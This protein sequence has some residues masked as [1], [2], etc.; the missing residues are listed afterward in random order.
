M[1]ALELAIMEIEEITRDGQVSADD[2]IGMMENRYNLDNYEVMQ[3]VNQ[4]CN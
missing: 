4:F 3:L 2:A 1:T